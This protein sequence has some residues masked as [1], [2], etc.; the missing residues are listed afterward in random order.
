MLI[1]PAYHSVVREQTA[2]ELRR[3]DKFE[4]L[5]IE[6]GLLGERTTQIP[7]S[8]CRDKGTNRSRNGYT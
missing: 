4:D 6:S 5:T 7:R 1:R 3:P 2:Q 8:E